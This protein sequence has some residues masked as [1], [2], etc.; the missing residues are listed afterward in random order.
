[1]KR[2]RK[3]QCLLPLRLTT[4]ILY[5]TFWGL[6]D[7]LKVTQTS[8]QSR[9]W[10]IWNLAWFSNKTFWNYFL[11]PSWT[12]AEAQTNRRK[13]AHTW[14]QS[15]M[16]CLLHVGAAP[17]PWGA[18]HSEN[19]VRVLGWL[20]ILQ[21]RELSLWVGQSTASDLQFELGPSLHIYASQFCV[22]ML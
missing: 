14:W 13:V 15:L 18:S 8:C 20:R 4:S 3:A 7:C 5:V 11:V 9:I 16:E 10:V 19:A 17:M 6:R 1:M 2:T 22:S 21:G 12:Q